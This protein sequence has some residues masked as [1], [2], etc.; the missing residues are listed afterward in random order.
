MKFLAAK[1]KKLSLELELHERT[2]LAKLRSHKLLG[3]RQA[4]LDRRKANKLDIARLCEEIL[5]PPVPIALRLSS[6]LMGGV[7]ILYEK[8]VMFLHDDANRFLVEI[9]NAWKVM[10]EPTL[11]PKRKEK[12][13]RKSITLPENDETSMG[14]TNAGEL[15]EETSM[16]FQQYNLNMQLDQ[17]DDYYITSD[18][19]EDIA[20]NDHHQADDNDITLFDLFQPNSNIRGQFERFEEAD[21]GTQVHFTLDEHIQIPTTPIPSPAQKEP[22]RA[23]G[24]QERHPEHQLDQ[25]FNKNREARDQQRQ[26]PVKQRRKPKGIITDEE[27]TVISN[28]VYHSWLHDTSDIASRIRRKNRGPASILSTYKIAKL[29][30]LPSTVIMDDMLLKGNQEISYPEPLLD[31]WKKSNQPLHDSPSVRTS[32]PQPQSQPQLHEP[33]SKE[34]VQSNYPMDYPFEDLHSGVGSPSHA[35]PIEVQRVNV[36]NKVTPSGINQFVS[37]GNSGDAVRYT[38]SSV[39]GDGVPSGNLEVNIERVG[40]KKKNVHST[41]KNSGSLDTVVEVF[42]EADTDFKLSRSKRKNLEPDHDF[43]VETQLTMETPADDPPDMMTENIKKHMKTHFETPGAPQVESLQN[44]AAG[45]NRKGAAQLFYRTCVLAS[46]G[47]L[48]VQQKVAFGDIFISKGA[49]M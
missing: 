43:L 35:A 33:S 39:S 38:G 17:V 45:L 6:I 16:G 46:Q 47:F 19:M 36:V 21:E 32:Q 7:V 48:K 5:N 9:R 23:G 34:R 37:P 24:T 10:N 41:S 8:K 15:E 12:A 20:T 26:G 3:T 2:P 31:L 4:K 42:R 1:K 22:Q 40:S 29:M 27:Q 25:Q 14:F 28:H 13:K 18:P 49:K 11:L 30:E 44:L